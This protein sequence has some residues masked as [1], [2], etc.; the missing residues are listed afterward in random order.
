M[1]DTATALEAAETWKRLASLVATVELYLT[2]RPGKSE[3]RMP[4]ASKPPID[5]VASDLL[6]ELDQA[7]TLYVAALLMETPDVKRFPDGL[8]AQLSLVGERYGHWTNDPDEKIGLDYCDEAHELMRK[9][10][11]LVLQPVPPQWMGPCQTCQEGDLWL[12]PERAFVTCDECGSAEDLVVLRERLLE[13]LRNSVVPRKEIAPALRLLGSKSSAKTVH[14]W[15]SRG[16]L[17][18]IIRKPEA[19]R[20]ADA[21]EL[22]KDLGV[23]V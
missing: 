14:Q 9:V 22:C 18:P 6:M 4:P 16:R 5:L 11:R 3:V 7:A 2:P 1:I 20:M 13:R 15:V 8:A 10:E 23:A 12:K 19:F 17:V 21:L